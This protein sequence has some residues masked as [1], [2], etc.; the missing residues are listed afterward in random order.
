LVFTLF[1][2]IRCAGDGVDELGCRFSLAAPAHVYRRIHLPL[3]R[4]SG[5]LRQTILGLALLLGHIWFVVGL[6]NH[7]SLSR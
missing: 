3:E 1:V 4:S 5:A 2:P 7:G 6:S